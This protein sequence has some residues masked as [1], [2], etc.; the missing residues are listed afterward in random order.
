MADII[1][2]D[3]CLVVCLKFKGYNIMSLME[4]LWEYFTVTVY[5]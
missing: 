5:M 4:F 1:K 2:A 3:T